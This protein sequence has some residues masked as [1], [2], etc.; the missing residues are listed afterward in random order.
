[1]PASKSC[2]HE[3]ATFH[4]AAGSFSFPAVPPRCDLTYEI[5][6]VEFE[7]VDEVGAPMLRLHLHLPAAPHF[8]CCNA[9][10]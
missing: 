6:L 7:A 4:H 9:S 10:I 8:S 1:M 3:S 2:Q 5:E